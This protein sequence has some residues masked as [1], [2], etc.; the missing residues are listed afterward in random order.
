MNQNNLL[1]DYF[2]PPVSSAAV[3]AVEEEVEAAEVE[4]AEVEA[5]EVEAVEVEEAEGATTLMTT[6]TPSLHKP[7]MGNSTER[8]QQYSQ[9]IER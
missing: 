9:G 2:K 4:A 1:V 5:A 8:N 3:E 7:Q 6:P